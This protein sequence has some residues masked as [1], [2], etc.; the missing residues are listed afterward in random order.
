MPPGRLHPEQGDL[1]L[2]EQ[3]Y[4][5]QHALAEHGVKVSSVELDL[6]TM[7]RRK[8]QIVSTN[9]RGIDALFKKNKITRYAGNGQIAGPSKVIVEAA[10]QSKTELSSKHILIATGSKPATLPG[11]QFDGDRIGTSSEA[12]SYP[13]VPK[14][15]VVVGAGYIGV[16]LGSVWRRLGS[17]VTVSSFSIASS[18]AR[19]AKSL[20]RR[21][22]F[23]RNRASSSAL[24]A[25]SRLLAFRATNASSSAKGPHHWSAIACSSQSVACHTPRGSASS[26]SASSS[27]PRGDSGERSLPNVGRRH[28]CDRRLHSRA[29]AR[30]KAEEEGVACVE[31]IVTGYGHVN[32]D[33]IPAVIFTQPEIAAVGKTEDQLQAA[34]TAYRKGIFPF[35]ANGRARTL[36][37][38]GG[39]VKILADEKT[40]RIIGVHVLGPIAPA[41]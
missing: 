36:G 35:R 6:A 19:T 5:T 31:R 25:G 13:E 37:Q 38:I 10:D 18:L 7:L 4:E 40:D 2:S 20:V 21:I 29:D 16:E 34:K 8:E 28:L 30:H 9:G 26:R 32:Y 23:Y 17:K 33:A 3:Y 11:I 15:L 12:L 22:R 24:A 27:T 1:E 39:K 41:T 14:H